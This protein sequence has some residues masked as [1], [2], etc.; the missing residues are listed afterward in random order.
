[1]EKSFSEF[2]SIFNY[3]NNFYRPLFLSSKYANEL[4]FS[5]DFLIYSL[6]HIGIGVFS[7]LLKLSDEDKFKEFVKKAK[8]NSEDV[9]VIE[10]KVMVKITEIQLKN[11]D[12]D[13]L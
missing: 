4:I 2:K 10:T 11:Y 12:I 1:M 9:F 7:D 8:R 3:L 13:E 5:D 6:I